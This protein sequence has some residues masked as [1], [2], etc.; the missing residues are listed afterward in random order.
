M[1]DASPIENPIRIETQTHW[2]YATLL[3]GNRGVEI[4]IWRR[5]PNGLRSL[6]RRQWVDWP[7]GEV[8]ERLSAIARRL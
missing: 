8:Y 5:I 3:D 4:T 2:Y 6:T 1:N 7:Y